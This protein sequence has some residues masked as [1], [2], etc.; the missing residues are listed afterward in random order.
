MKENTSHLYAVIMAGGKGERFWPAGR[1]NHPK[2][3]LS[4]SGDTTMIEDTVQRLFP[5]ICPE[6]VFVITNAAYAGQIREL[7]PIPAENVIGEPV[8]RDTAPCAALAAAV[9]SKRDPDATMILLPADHVIRPAKLFQQTLYHA[10]QL[11]GQGSLVTL[12]ITPSAPSTGYGYIHVG[13]QITPG[14][15]KALAFREK[16]DHATALQYF[17]D[18]SYLWNSGIFL[19][20]IRTVMAAFQKYVPELYQKALAWSHGADFTKDFADCN[21]ISIDY[22]VM[23]KA[24]NV[25]VGDAP[26][27]WNDIGSWSSLKSVLPSDEN[28][29]A[30]SGKVIALDSRDNVILCNDDTLLAV[31][32][33]NNIA[34]VKSGNGLLVCPLSSEQ[35]V[36]ELV[37]K[38]EQNEPE[39][40]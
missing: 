38:I 9:V 13:E 33:M 23:E 32:D 19:W 29:N 36:K 31:V 20:Q 28:N 21:K 40:L 15:S 16:P 18:G 34:V 22:A 6:N 30:L 3:L 24:D 27:Y 11:A 26:F 2:Q 1:Q 25:L 39:Y 5:L 14:F 35:R 8:G 37:K 4:L 10:A 12:G 7:L 17:R